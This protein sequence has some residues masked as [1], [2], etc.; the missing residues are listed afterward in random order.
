VNFPLFVYGTLMSAGDQAVLLS[1]LGRSSATTRGALYH[2]PAG[3]PAL[4]LG[5]DGEVHGELVEA[6]EAR[7]LALLDH[8]EGVAQGLYRR[9]TIDVTVGL[10]RVKAWAYV[11]DR[12][13]SL[14]GK[15]LQ[16]GRWR[17]I[18]RR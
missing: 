2:L 5:P 17:C 6:P 13:E 3:Y 18:R 14:G 10:R 7:L 11:M 1:G 4:M 16:S 8:Y 12:P 15:R 9:E